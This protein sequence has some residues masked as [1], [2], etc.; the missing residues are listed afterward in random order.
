MA[1]YFIFLKMNIVCLVLDQLS[2]PSQHKSVKWKSLE[3]FVCFPSYMF[4]HKI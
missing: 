1:I 2:G 3:V 4:M